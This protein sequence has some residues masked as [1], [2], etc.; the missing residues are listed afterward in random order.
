[1]EHPL[2][3]VPPADQPRPALP[4][5]PV[6]PAVRDWG[7]WAA[8]PL[9]TAGAWLMAWP[10]A[11]YGAGLMALAGATGCGVTKPCTGRNLADL[12]AGWAHVYLVAALAWPLLWAVPPARGQRARRNLRGLQLSLVVG[13]TAYLIAA[14]VS[15]QA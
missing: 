5:Q 9:I 1:V 4:P 6:Q 14:A 12:D 8:I 3:P 7:H 15:Y 13:L 10:F 2:P 11:W